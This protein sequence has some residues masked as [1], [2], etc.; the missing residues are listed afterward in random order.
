MLKHEYRFKI[1]SGESHSREGPDE[2]RYWGRCPTATRCLLHIYLFTMYYIGHGLY[3]HTLQ[4]ASRL[5]RRRPLVSALKYALRVR[6]PFPLSRRTKKTKPEEAARRNPRLTVSVP[7]H[8]R[9]RGTSAE[10]RWSLSSLQHLPHLS[11]GKRRNERY[12]FYRPFASQSLSRWCSISSSPYLQRLEGRNKKC[13]I[14]RAQYTK[15]SVR[16]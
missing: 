4:T 16:I 8:P 15:R 3:R 12:A 6:K 2:H 7:L 5:G 1:L 10:H 14:T 9:Y 11:S 13:I